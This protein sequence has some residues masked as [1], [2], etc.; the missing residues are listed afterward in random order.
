MVGSTW[1]RTTSSRN[2]FGNAFGIMLILPAANLV[3]TGQESPKPSAVPT[4]LEDSM[5]MHHDVIDYKSHECTLAR[6][7]CIVKI[8]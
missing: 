7:E 4:V 2:S 6:R 8:L 1:N 3:A 5:P